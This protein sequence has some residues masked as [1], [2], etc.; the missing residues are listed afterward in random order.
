MY[1]HGTGSKLANMDIDC[2]GDQSDHGDGRCGSSEDTQSQTAFKDLV[3]KYSKQNGDKVSDLNANFIPYVVFG[4]YGKKKGYT[5]FHPE[6]LGLKALSVMAVVCGDQLVSSPPLTHLSRLTHQQ[7]YGVW[8]DT[9][10]DD[11]EPLVGETSLSLAT[12]CF[13]KSMNGNNGHSPNDVLYIAFPG[14]VAETVEKKA[15][16][17]AKNFTDFEASIKDVGDRLVRKL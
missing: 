14:T 5:N 4:N 12:K 8:G 16:W 17:G 10:G 2:D 6:D 3:Q 11:G 1:L 7:V 15:D 13:G 9:N